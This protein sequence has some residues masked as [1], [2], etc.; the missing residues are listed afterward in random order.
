MTPSHTHFR[1]VQEIA[2]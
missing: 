1:S 2:L